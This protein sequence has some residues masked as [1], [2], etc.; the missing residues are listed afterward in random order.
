[1]LLFV[2]K[3]HK[4]GKNYI[5]HSC[6]KGNSQITWQITHCSPW[7]MWL[8]VFLSCSPANIIPWTSEYD[9]WCHILFTMNDLNL[10]GILILVAIQKIA[11]QV[12][13]SLPFWL[14]LHRGRGVWLSFVFPNGKDSPWCNA[15]DCFQWSIFWLTCVEKWVYVLTLRHLFVRPSSVENFNVGLFSE[16]MNTR[17]LRLGM[18]EVCDRTC[19]KISFGWSPLKVKVTG[20]LGEVQKC[21][22]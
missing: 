2:L 3:L 4:I 18:R 11:T 1:M 12:V 8:L 7:H 20:A 21:Q 16:T 15:C 13:R 19:L 10:A 22:L 9:V 14:L 17:N 5:C 6:P